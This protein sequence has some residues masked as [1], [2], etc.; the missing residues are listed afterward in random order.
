MSEQAKQEPKFQVPDSMRNPAEQAYI[1]S[2]ISAAVKEAIM[3]MAPILQSVAMTPEKMLEMERLRRAPGE[4]EVRAKQREARERK[5]MKEDLQEA[6]RNKKWIQDNCPGPHKD[7][8]GKWS[9]SIIHNYPDRMPRGVC[10]HCHL[11]IEP[12]HWEI[13]SPTDKHPRGEPRL[14][15]ASPLYKT[16]LEIEQTSGM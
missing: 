13:G 7:K 11:F 9:I 3:A 15:P 14:V 8:N 1:N 2:S 6:E 5:L 16:V 10:T 12:T 4:D